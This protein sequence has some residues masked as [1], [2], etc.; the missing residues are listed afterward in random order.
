MAVS[1]HNDMLVDMMVSTI[2]MLNLVWI[3]VPF[4]ESDIVVDSPWPTMAMCN[5]LNSVKDG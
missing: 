3:G 5:P 1:L 4:L 2:Y